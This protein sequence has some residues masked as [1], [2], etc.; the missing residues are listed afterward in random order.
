MAK[1]EKTAKDYRIR[2]AWRGLVSTQLT[3]TF[4]NIGKNARGTRVK[5][6]V[7]E[8]GLALLRRLEG[9]GLI[10]LG[11]VTVSYQLTTLGDE[12]WTHQYAPAELLKL[13]KARNG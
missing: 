2:N 1:L 13:L 9:L 12:V 8:G 6:N 4:K 3:E 7:T 10:E 11:Y 5:A